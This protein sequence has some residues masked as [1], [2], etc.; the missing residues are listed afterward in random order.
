MM[1]ETAP[2]AISAHGGKYAVDDDRDIPD[3]MEV[4]YEFA[5]GAIITFS[6]FEASSGGHSHMVK[7]NSGDKRYTLCR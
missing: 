5:S 4:T 6:I 7:L 3:T 2:V 1:G